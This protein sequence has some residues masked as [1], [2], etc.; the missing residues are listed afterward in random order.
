MF[1]LE[2]SCLIHIDITQIHGSIEFTLLTV[3]FFL[4][5]RAGSIFVYEL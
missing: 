4:K 5:R 3:H 1:H 2:N